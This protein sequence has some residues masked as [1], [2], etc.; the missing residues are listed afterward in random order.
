MKYRTIAW[1]TRIDLW[2]RRSDGWWERIALREMCGMGTRWYTA[3]FPLVQRNP[4]AGAGEVM[5]DFTEDE[6]LETYPELLVEMFRTS[7]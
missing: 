5:K 1:G 3:V 6:I 2:Q 4:D 7:A